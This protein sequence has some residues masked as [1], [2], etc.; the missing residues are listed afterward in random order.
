MTDFKTSRLSIGS[1]L[2]TNADLVE[3]AAELC[4][5]FDMA[6]VFDTLLAEPEDVQNYAVL[7]HLMRGVCTQEEMERYWALLPADLAV[8][9]NHI[10]QDSSEV[11]HLAVHKLGEMITIGD[12]QQVPQ[13]PAHF[14]VYGISEEG[15]LVRS[16]REPD[17]IGRWPKVACLQASGVLAL[18]YSPEATV[19]D[20]YH[21]VSGETTEPLLTEDLLAGL[22]ESLF[23]IQPRKNSSA[24]TKP[25]KRP[26]AQQKQAKFTFLDSFAQLLVPHI[27]SKPEPEQDQYFAR[28]TIR[29]SQSSILPSVKSSTPESPDKSYHHEYSVPQ[30]H[31][32]NRIQ[33]MQEIEVLPEPLPPP[34]IALL[35]RA[36]RVKRPADM[37][38][39]EPK[40]PEWAPYEKKA[41]RLSR[42]D[43]SLD[44]NCVI[45]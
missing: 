15:S 10:V 35:H 36:K 3:T 30:K 26:K 13:L 43:C 21:P 38:P 45:A 16:V 9:L 44:G 12:L 1:V 6:R 29:S 41:I 32:N 14:T 27:R 23:F 37:T 2:M 7:E 40:D 28:P 19:L 4:Q 5:E 34:R 39:I 31:S 8:K 22:T 33:N 24:Q 42:E 17:D 18:L 25:P 20:G 11:S